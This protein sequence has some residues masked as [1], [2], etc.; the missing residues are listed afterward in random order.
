[1]EYIEKYLSVPVRLHPL[2][3]VLYNRMALGL[4]SA[5][6]ELFRSQLMYAILVF[7]T[8]FEFDVFTTTKVPLMFHVWIKLVSDGPRY[9]D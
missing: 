4:K 2:E 6:F 1:M 8:V 5:I 7:V 3:L 9:Q